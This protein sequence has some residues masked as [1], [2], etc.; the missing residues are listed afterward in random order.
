MFRQLR[1]IDRHRAFTSAGLVPLTAPES[2]GR[3]Y[4]HGIQITR[5]SGLGIQS[6]LLMDR[7]YGEPFGF[8]CPL[9]ADDLIGGKAFDGHQPS[10]EIVGAD[11]V[12]KLISQLVVVVVV[13]A[14]DVASLI[15]QFIRS[16]WLFVQG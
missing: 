6:R 5:L 8:D 16:T 7:V 9:F 11:E 2:Y 10:P 4:K 13:E 1:Q 12:G 15:V 3:R 14:S